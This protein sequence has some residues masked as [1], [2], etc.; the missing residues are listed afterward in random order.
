M[1][2]TTKRDVL[3]PD[4]ANRLLKKVRGLYSAAAALALAL[5]GLGTWFIYD[6]VNASDVDL[7]PFHA[8]PADPVVVT[9]TAACGFSNEGVDPDGGAGFLVTCELDLSDPRVT[10][11]ETHDRFRFY[12]GGTGVVWVAE[13]A[14][15]A[16]GEGTWRGSAQSADDGTPIGEARYMGEGTYAGLVFHYYFSHINLADK[17][18]VRGW[19]S[20]GE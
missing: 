16:N 19:I 11:T 4:E 5:L 2:L 12:E 8:I 15:I 20:S 18:Q 13:E 7:A 6:L 10:G 9:G 1:T 14:V 17:A 3:E